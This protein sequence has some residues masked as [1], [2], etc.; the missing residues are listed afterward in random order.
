MY[1]MWNV[2]VIK[3][4]EVIVMI[5]N[6]SQSSKKDKYISCTSYFFFIIQI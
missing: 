3:V 2:S 5:I 6:N 1:E 4:I